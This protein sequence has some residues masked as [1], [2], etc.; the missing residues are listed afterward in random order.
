MFGLVLIT[1]TSFG[2][3][4]HFFPRIGC[5]ISRKSLYEA[6]EDQGGIGSEAYRTLL[7]VNSA[8]QNG[9]FVRVTDNE[10]ATVTIFNARY[11]D[12]LKDLSERS[13][14]EAQ[15][16][17]FTTVSEV[18]VQKGYVIDG[19]RYAFQR[20]SLDGVNYKS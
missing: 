1:Q 19:D 5:T 15:K 12:T 4:G 17:R 10:D 20:G 7:P 2:M 16:K 13:N 11:T 6:L 3:N 8:L 18:S 9:F 14:N